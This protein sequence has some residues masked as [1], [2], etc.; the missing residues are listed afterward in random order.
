MHMFNYK[1]QTLTNKFSHASGCKK[2]HVMGC[3]ELIEGWNCIEQITEAV[4]G[5]NI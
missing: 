5:Y 2:L 1:K 4:E 3:V